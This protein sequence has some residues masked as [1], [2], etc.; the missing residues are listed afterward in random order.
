[1]P[2]YIFVV[3]VVIFIS[4]YRTEF[5][6]V[7]FPQLAKE[8][9]RWA[10]FLG[11]PFNGFEESRLITAGVQWTLKYECFLPYSSSASGAC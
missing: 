7:S 1:M 4:L 5:D 3:A 10:V 6:L 2:L 9:L 8:I 11:A